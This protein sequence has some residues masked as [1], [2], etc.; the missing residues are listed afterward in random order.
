MLKNDKFTFDLN[1][2][3]EHLLSFKNLSKANKNENIKDIHSNNFLFKY[4]Y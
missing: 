1:N 4:D 3:I 2:K